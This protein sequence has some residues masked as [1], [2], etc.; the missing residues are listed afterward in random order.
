MPNIF[1]HNHIT[2]QVYG[3]EHA[4]VMLGSTLPDFIGMYNA[5]YSHEHGKVE[6]P[7]MNLALVEGIAFHKQTDAVYDAQPEIPQITEPLRQDLERAGIAYKA[8]RLTTAFAA[9]ILLDRALLDMEVPPV[10]F[11]VIRQLAK[12]N[13]LPVNND[14][15]TRLTYHIRRYFTGYAPCAYRNPRNIA[16]MAQRRLRTRNAPDKRLTDNQ[17]SAVTEV[18][19]AHADRVGELG[20]RALFGTLQDLGAPATEPK[21]TQAQLRE[22]SR[23]VRQATIVGRAL[24]H[25]SAEAEL[26]S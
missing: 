21:V 19:E 7:S 20:L 9:D 15:D 24:K 1:A 18:L 11:E 16:E 8:A 12:Q 6:L 13:R 22:F 5:R 4:D 25:S 2:A 23:R 26:Q 3:P 17:L 14:L 10:N